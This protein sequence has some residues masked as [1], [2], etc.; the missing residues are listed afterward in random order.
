MRWLSVARKG[1]RDQRWQVV[2]FGLT[3]TLMAASIVFLWPSYRTTVASIQLPQAVQALLGSDLAYSTAPGFVSAEYFSWIPILLIVYT[4][5]QGTGAIAGEEGS[6]T[7]D[8]LMSQPITRWEMVVQKTIGVCVGAAI[9]AGFGFLGFLLSVPFV[10]INLTLKGAALASANML[11]MAIFYYAVSLWFGA[12]LPNRAY[13]AGG[14]TA[15]T[16][17]GYFF[18]TIAAAVHSLSGLKYASP[19]YYYGAGEPLVR[20]LDW[21]H[22]GLLL[23][24]SALFVVAAIRAF[25][26]RDITIGG[27]SNLRWS[28]V[29]GRVLGLQRYEPSATS[30]GSTSSA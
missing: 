29:V 26:G 13:A 20:G 3:F 21:D 28:D 8:L 11:P 25:A 19:F 30:P 16:T 2:G 5:I 23:G 24:I 27:A 17:L 4:V 18:N 15:L 10:D 9:I 1:L 22:V 14:A 7:I 12:V 6:G